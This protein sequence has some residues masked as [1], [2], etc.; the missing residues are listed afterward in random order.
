LQTSNI[1]GPAD[2][3]IMIEGSNSIVGVRFIRG[4]TP[5]P[6][7]VCKGRGSQLAKI[8]DIAVEKKIP[9]YF[10]EELASGLYRSHEPGGTLGELYF[11]RFI[12]ALKA[13]KLV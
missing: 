13:V 3:T 12:S 10:D 2:A 1:Y 6:L 5:I 11:E 8:A 7:I 4:E 9:K